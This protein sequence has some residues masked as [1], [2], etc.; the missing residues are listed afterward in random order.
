M[1]HCHAST[2]ARCVETQLMWDI[3]IALLGGCVQ[4]PILAA[5]GLQWPFMALAAAQMSS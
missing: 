1:Q 5:H 3:S 2:Q 4:L